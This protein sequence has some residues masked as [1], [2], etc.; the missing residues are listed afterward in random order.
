MRKALRLAAVLLVPA[1][2]GG[3]TCARETCA[4]PF[5]LPAGRGDDLRPAHAALDALIAQ[6]SK[7]FGVP[8]S[9]IRAVMQAESGGRTTLAEG[10][11]IVSDAGAMGLMQLMPSTWRDMRIQYGFGRDPFDPQ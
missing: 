2:A 10:K 5:R 6:A 1:I 7:R 3:A 8:P 9:W 4:G 11:P